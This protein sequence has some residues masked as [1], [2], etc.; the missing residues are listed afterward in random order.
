MI[1]IGAMPDESQVF[2]GSIEQNLQAQ[3]YCYTYFVTK[4]LDE[5]SEMDTSS[6]KCYIFLLCRLYYLILMQKEMSQHVSTMNMLLS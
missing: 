4:I 3:F 1:G 2:K 6:D 5:C